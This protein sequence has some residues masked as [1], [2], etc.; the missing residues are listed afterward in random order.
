[1]ADPTAKP[2]PKT[3]SKWASEV[4]GIQKFLDQRPRVTPGRA[5]NWIE[6][7]REYYTRRLNYLLDNKPKVRY[8]KR[9]IK[10]C[11]RG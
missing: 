3:L 4:E 6:G 10:R 7:M 9:K 5:G 8:R 1:M 11:T 2:V